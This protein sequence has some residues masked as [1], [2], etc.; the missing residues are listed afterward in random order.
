MRGC[1]A[2]LAGKRQSAVP[3][4]HIWVRVNSG[5]WSEHYLDR[6]RGSQKGVGGNSSSSVLR[7]SKARGRAQFRKLRANFPIEGG[8]LRRSRSFHFLS[9]LNSSQA[10]RP[11]APEPGR[12]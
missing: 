1:A 7:R 4:F 10:S 8:E 5:A 11:E 2:R 12:R 6:N 9:A 3:A